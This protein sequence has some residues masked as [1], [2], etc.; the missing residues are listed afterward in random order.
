MSN[1]PK[2]KKCPSCHRNTLKEQSYGAY[3]TNCG[4]KNDMGA[5]EHGTL[6]FKQYKKREINE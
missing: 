2:L 4:Y 1:R 5:L 3:C 6:E